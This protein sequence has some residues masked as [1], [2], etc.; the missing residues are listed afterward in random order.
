VACR[1]RRPKPL[2]RH[3]LT[4]D[5]QSAALGS[6]CLHRPIDLEASLPL[7]YHLPRSRLL[8]PMPSEPAVLLEIRRRAQTTFF[9]NRCPTARISGLLIS[10]TG[11]RAPPTKAFCSLT[12]AT[13]LTTAYAR[14]FE[15]ST[16]LSLRRELPSSRMY[17]SRARRCWI[18][19]SSCLG[20]PSP[21]RLPSS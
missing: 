9:L 15:S 12:Q 3:M 13:P 19:V 7:N 16:P 4:P 14:P 6:G 10:E 20:R 5:R 11:V 2:G 21:S 18:C 17:P 8:S 1:Q